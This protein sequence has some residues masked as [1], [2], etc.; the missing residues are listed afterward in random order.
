MNLPQEKQ[1]TLG[2]YLTAKEA[3]E[4]W[5]ASP[6]QIKILDVRTFNEYVNVGHAPMAWN[7]PVFFQKEQWDPEK[8]TIWYYP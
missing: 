8:K 3:Y 5:K 7:I 4:N 2:L 1:T 6:D